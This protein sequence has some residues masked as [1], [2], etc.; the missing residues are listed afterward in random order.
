MPRIR[1]LYLLHGFAVA[2]FGPFASVILADRGFAPAAIGLVYAIT[3]L[4]YVVSVPAWGHL[5]DVVLGRSRALRLALVGAAAMLLLF[6]LPLALPL[7]AV[8]YVGYAA[9]YGAAGPL[10]DALAVNALRDPTRQY[11]QVRALLS[12]SFTVTA[13]G[14]GVLY[15]IAGYWPAPFL[16][17]GFA[18]VL[19][20]LGGSIPDLKR[21]TLVV[22][23]RGGA[24]REALAIQPAIVRVLVAVGI[25]H[26]GV[27]AGFSFLSLRVVELGGGPPQVALSSATAAAA[28]VVAMVAAGRIVRRVGLRTMFV[29]TSLLSA[30]AF[31]SWVVLTTPEAIIV[32]RVL[33][34]T[35]Y[36]GVFI[37]GVTSMQLLLPPR[38][39]GSGQALASMTTAGIAAF[40]ANVLGG[41]IYGGPGHQVLFGVGAAFAVVGAVLG[42]LWL[43]RRGTKR[44]TEPPATISVST[45]A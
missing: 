23:R 36:A 45:G 8:A 9:C 3:S 41:V 4:T 14:F 29:G 22:S 2:A 18:L 26:V 34:G 11:G 42:W 33:S 16:F 13:I 37:A 35:G 40:V 1:L 32:S 39:Q 31:A 28:E 30:V 43:P 6:A 5:G 10:S 44:F 15:G 17:V 24:I 27:F 19:A 21:A 25:A 38:L 20:W 7:M 12:A